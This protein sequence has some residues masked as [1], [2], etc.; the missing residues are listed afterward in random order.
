MLF[1]FQAFLIP[2]HTAIT[3][4]ALVEP[5]DVL[6]TAIR[7]FKE[8]GLL[9]ARSY[10]SLFLA[11]SQRKSTSMIESKGPTIVL[12]SNPFTLALCSGK[13]IGEKE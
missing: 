7:W 10:I 5:L 8:L 6:E 4:E 13:M 9:H 2:R 3:I 11:L 1:S 12:V